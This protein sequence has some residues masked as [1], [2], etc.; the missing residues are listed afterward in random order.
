MTAAT[1]ERPP[2]GGNGTALAVRPAKQSALAA[3][4]ERFAI[5]PG[6][7]MEVLK[8][9]VIK[10]PQGRQATNEECAAFIVVANQYNLNPFT[11]EIHAFADGQRG[12]VPIVGVDGWSKIVNN[13]PRFDGCEFEEAKGD[14]GDVGLTCTMYVKERSHPVRITEWLSEC[15]RNTNPWNTMRRR[16]LRHKA[17]MQAARYAFSISGIYDEDEARDII[18]NSAPLAGPVAPP[19]DRV[20]AKVT[21][22]P[23]SE[24]QTYIPEPDVLNEAAQAVAD[25]QAIATV[26]AETG[27]A[28]DAAT[29]PTAPP[30]DPLTE[31]LD[32]DWSSARKVLIDAGVKA[33]MTR[34]NAVKLVDSTATAKGEMLL[35]MADKFEM[36]RKL[37]AKHDA[38]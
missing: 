34:A 6:R 26:D 24:G 8:A 5:E 15:K 27:E 11:R 19:M 22:R 33:G 20:L 29:E 9:T 31:A 14:D 4:A 16:M 17:F 18:G 36:H 23:V 7:L 35:T 37:T 38:G 21:Q 30:V 28:M 10:G 1:L 13:Q 12:I 25:E 2:V 3:M 32:Q